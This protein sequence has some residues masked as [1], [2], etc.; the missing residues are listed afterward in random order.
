MLNPNYKYISF[1]LE[2]TGLNKN[3]DEIIQIALVSFDAQGNILKKFSS[4][5]RPEQVT[6]KEFISYLTGIDNEQIKTAPVFAK[7]H[8]EVE[9]FFDEYTIIVGHNIQFDIGFLQKYIPDLRYKDHIDTY[10][11][12][13]QFVHF[14]ASYALEVLVE[15]LYEKQ[16]I[17]REIQQKY[18]WNQHEHQHHDAMTDTLNS[19]SLFWY[20]IRKIYSIC[21]KYPDILPLFEKID[22]LRKEIIENRFLSSP[23]NRDTVQKWQEKKQEWKQ[24]WKQWWISWKTPKI[25]LPVLERTSPSRASLVNKKGIHLQDLPDKSSY[26]IWNSDLETVLYQLAGNK[27]TILCFDSLHKLNIAKNILTEKGIPCWAMYDQQTI[28]R[29]KLINFLNKDKFSTDEL[30]FVLKYLSTKLDGY[31]IIQTNTPIDYK[32]MHYIKKCNSFAKSSLILSTH[33]ALFANKD[34]EKLK[35]YSIVFFDSDWWYKNYNQRISRNIDGYGLVYFLETLLYS[36]QIQKDTELSH[37]LQLMYEKILMFVGVLSLESKHFLE[38]RK[39]QQAQWVNPLIG[40]EYFLKTASLWSEITQMQDLILWNLDSE[41]MEMLCNKFQEVDYILHS[42]VNITQRVNYNTVGAGDEYF[43]LSEH[44]KF[45]DRSEFTLLFDQYHTIFLSHTTKS[46]PKLFTTNAAP[47]NH[48][49]YSRVSDTQNILQ[50]IIEEHKNLWKYP[51]YFILSTKKFESQSIFN[52]IIQERI[53]SNWTI[54]GENITWWA[55]KNIF[56]IKK[57]GKCIIIWGY[58]FLLN[59][60]AHDIFPHRCIIH[61]I[62]GST[63]KLILRD[64][65][66]YGKQNT[67]T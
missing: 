64:I 61:N 24:E 35:G 5:V 23:I 21:E 49:I 20:C 28:D 50:K 25:S 16:I 65:V 10:Q 54:L 58:Q 12:A 60:Y 40:N 15:H 43:I 14:P 34:D 56:R 22:G 38:M 9:S 3:E 39:T 42:L 66:W 26:Y 2:T 47:I 4:L 41:D 32:I 19:W 8:E 6:I 67:S 33:N 30:F 62:Y 51:I 55:G 18:L 36:Y 1:D 13:K 11:L 45:T 31:S 52:T 53:F 7:I 44:I 27:H 46:Y 29:E 17:F 48:N 59:V 63:E 57:S 37:E